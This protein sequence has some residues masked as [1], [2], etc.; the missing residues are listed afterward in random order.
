LELIAAEGPGV[1]HR[2]ELAELISRDVSDR[3]GLLTLEDLA[4]YEPVVRPALVSRAGA[5]TLSTTPPPS[6]GGVCLAAM[7]RL[8]LAHPEENPLDPDHVVAVQRAVLGHRLAVLDHSPDLV[9]AAGDFLDRVDR[10]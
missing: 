10:D 2:G 8:L 1:L 3:G 5:W 9:A 4:A 7:L 6:V